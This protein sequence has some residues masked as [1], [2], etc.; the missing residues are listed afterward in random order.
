VTAVTIM[1]QVHRASHGDWHGTNETRSTQTPAA[2]SRAGDGGLALESGTQSGL[3]VSES[4]MGRCGPAAVWRAGP[5][6][7]PASE[8]RQRK[9]TAVVRPLQLK[10]RAS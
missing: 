5:T 8:A 10:E 4:V 6:A 1:I 7:E 2:P 9:V 3:P